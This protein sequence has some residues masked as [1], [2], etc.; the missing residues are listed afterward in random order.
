M[1]L[2]CYLQVDYKSVMALVRG[3]D[4]ES[5]PEETPKRS[6]KLQDKKGAA[7]GKLVD[8]EESETDD[9]D[10]Y[11]DPEIMHTEANI[12]VKGK[13]RSELLQLFLSQ[14]LCCNRYQ[15][16]QSHGRGGRGG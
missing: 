10:A 2:V 3:E 9:E 4:D 8:G 7:K 15:L 14:Q 13:N 12:R 6:H 16:H 5:D 1:K 11:H